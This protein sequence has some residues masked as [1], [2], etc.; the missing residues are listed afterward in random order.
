MIMGSVQS[1]T[2]SQANTITSYNPATGEA[3][4][5][6]EVAS[7][8]QV[9]I[10]VNRARLAQATWGVL[11]PRERGRR[12]L[13][14][15]KLLSSRCEE[16]ARQ[17]STENGKTVFEALTMEVV[18]LADL[19]GYYSKR[20]HKV[21]QTRSISLHLLKHRKSYL[22]YVPRGVVAIISPWNFPFMIPFGETVM[23]L[24]AGN[25]VIIKPSEVT[26]LIANT[27]LDL[28][29]EAGLPP[30]LVQVV[31]GRGDVGAA[32]VDS[33]VNYVCF[34]GSVTTGRKVAAACGERLIPCTM[35]L[36]GKA[37][38]IVS[39]DADLE[40]T[41][42]ALVWGAFANS[43][44]ICA[45]VERVYAHESI[46]DDLV[47]RVV[48]KAGRLRQG[49]P[50][51]L[52]TDVG[53]ICFGRQLEVARELIDDAVHK[54]AKVELGGAALSNEPGMFFQPTIL[55]GVDHTMRCMHEES[56]APLMPIMSVRSDTEALR[57]ANDSQ[58]G[59]LGYVFTRDHSKGRRLAEQIAA[60]TVM[61]NDVL[62]TYGAPETP[63]AGIKDSGLGR[64]HSDDG[65]R[66]LCEARHVNHE[67]LITLPR[68]LFWY[69]YGEKGYRRAVKAMR[70][71]FGGF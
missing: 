16:L 39:D 38:A 71:F 4:G 52:T 32:L 69:P 10:A 7:A 57:L 31:H 12:V 11:P 68:E 37:P 24:L 36:G 53:A 20:V 67:N 58:L 46:H 15:R 65:L 59:L 26:P 45:S 13:R 30:D 41:S 22:H 25:S 70:L 44:Q 9:T 34:T 28:V 50:A 21:L 1:D 55:T 8:E 42:Q 51:S 47:G 29:Q 66:D 18:G 43:G 62:V 5:E 19:V 54:G 49:S 48:E 64:V 17:I 33:G 35:E 6:V 14:L 23:A 63:W 2:A 56:F 3:L 27:I 40:R 61:V 60:G